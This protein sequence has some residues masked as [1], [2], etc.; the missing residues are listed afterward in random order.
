[1]LNLTFF[2]IDLTSQSFNSFSNNLEIVTLPNY[3][4][5]R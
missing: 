5:E 2:Q 4:V 3:V 1:M